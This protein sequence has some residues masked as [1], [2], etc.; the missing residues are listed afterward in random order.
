M[1]AKNKLLLA[2]LQKVCGD[3]QGVYEFAEEFADEGTL[4]DLDFAESEVK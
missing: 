1:S 3:M 2:M 4:E